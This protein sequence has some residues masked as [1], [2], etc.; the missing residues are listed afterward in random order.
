MPTENSDIP[1][2]KKMFPTNPFPDVDPRDFNKLNKE[3]VTED[4]VAENLVLCGWKVFEPFTDTGIDMIIS[5]EVCPYGHTSLF[6][7][8]KYLCSRCQSKPISILRFLQVKTRSLKGQIFGFT[9]RPK[10]LRVDPRHVYLL[11]CDTTNDFFIVPVFDYLSF[12]EKIR[13]NPF[14]APSFRRENQKLNSLRYDKRTGDW[15][16]GS[17]SWEDFRNVN[18]LKLLQNPDIDINL[19]KWVQ[20]TRYLYN[21]LVITFSSGNTYGD[22]IEKLVQNALKIRRRLFSDKSKAMQEKENQLSFLRR[23]IRDKFLFGSIMKY[24]ETVKNLEIIGEET[25]KRIKG[26]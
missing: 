3:R 5:K 12:F 9:V 14:S 26:E 8:E 24:W 1:L 20:R 25:E 11:Y 10:D 17:H 2:Q 23:S 6:S 16:W 7:S 4:Y 22:E 13:S 21:K 15:Y 19:E 18:G